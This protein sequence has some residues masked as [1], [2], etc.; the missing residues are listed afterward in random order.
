ML[1]QTNPTSSSRQRQVKCPDMRPKHLIGAIP[2]LR[3]LPLGV[4]RHAC[5]ST[6]EQMTD[7]QI[8]ALKAL[9]ELATP[10]RSVTCLVSDAVSQATLLRQSERRGSGHAHPGQWYATTSSARP[11]TSRSRSP[12]ATCAPPISGVTTSPR[13]SCAIEPEY[14]E[15]SAAAKAKLKSQRN[16]DTPASGCV[17]HSRFG[18]AADRLDGPWPDNPDVL[19]R[20][21]IAA[22]ARLCSF[23]N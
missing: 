14:G 6:D 21:R 16:E 13:R 4:D 23:W 5:V 19:Y 1:S 22:W 20:R 9:R 11:A 18:P 2:E 12:A 10:L 8:D 17:S 15:N 7:P 3:R